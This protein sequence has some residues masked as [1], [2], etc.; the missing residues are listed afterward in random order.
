MFPTVWVAHLS[1]P[2][3]RVSL[4]LVFLPPSPRGLSAETFFFCFRA[5]AKCPPPLPRYLPPKLACKRKEGR[6]EGRLGA[7]FYARQVSRAKHP[8]RISIASCR[9]VFFFGKRISKR[10]ELSC[11]SLFRRYQHICEIIGRLVSFYFAPQLASVCFCFSYQ[12]LRKTL[13]TLILETLWTLFLPIQST[14]VKLLHRFCQGEVWACAIPTWTHD[15]GKNLLFIKSL[16][17]SSCLSTTSK[18]IICDYQSTIESVKN[19]L[20]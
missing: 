5:P 18:L 10:H 17:S 9:R 4:S 2:S 6:G 16:L 7:L 8:W 1:T 14:V 19:T 3:W 13:A 12:C 11:V 20:Q 15:A